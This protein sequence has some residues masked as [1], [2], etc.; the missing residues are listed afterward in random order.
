L[1][2]PKSNKP[3]ISKSGT[4]NRHRDLTR[5]SIT[6]HLFALAIPAALGMIF[7][8]LYNL[9]DLWFAGNLSAH[10]LEAVSISATVFF[11]IISA[12]V[13]MQTGT[14]AVVATEIGRDPDADISGW[15]AAAT[16]LGLWVTF[17]ILVVGLL[18]AEW[19]VT[20]LGAKDEVLK[21]SMR[22]VLVVL[23]GAVGLVLSGVAAGA[24]IATGDTVTNRNA[25]ALGFFANIIL[26]A[27]FIYALKL[28]VTGL[29]MATV[30][31]KIG[32]TWYLY[33]VISLRVGRWIMPTVDFTKWQELLR[34]VIPATM[35]M[36]TMI[37]GGF[38]T[39]YYIG[40][41]G[42]QHVAGY[43]VGLRLE[44]ILLLPAL[45]LNA[46]VLALVGQNVGAGNKKRA[47]EAFN[48]ALKF[49]LCIALASIPAMVFLSPKLLALFTSDPQI[50]ATGTTY[51][52]IDAIAFYAYVVI[53]ICVATL[54]ALKQPMFPLF[55]GIAR[56]LILPTLINYFLIVVY[57]FP[58]YTL[59]I[60]IITVV[61]ISSFVAFFY[62]KRQLDTLV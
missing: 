38:I 2:S 23:W 57:S 58:M 39:V 61:V 26:N 18:S 42:S 14:A 20:F 8:T 56:H 45:G 62:T 37:V 17:L 6:Q 5:G 21:L 9:T 25:L 16:G 36:L 32:T 44:Q 31:I 60:T 40:R 24:L 30:I 52:R 3:Q 53:F 49:G 54:Q 51:L 27:L 1:T 22:Y 33:R 35:N 28:G 41:F 13:G 29:A 12:S 48:T 4:T 55:L 11:F 34:Q 43:S 46:A 19:M 47:N 15:I 59:F 10:A 50:I 7:N